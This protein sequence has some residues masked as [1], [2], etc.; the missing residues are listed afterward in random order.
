MEFEQK[1]CFSLT[2]GVLIFGTSVAVCNKYR[3]SREGHRLLK[4]LSTA[5]LQGYEQKVI[6]PN[7]IWL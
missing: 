7:P 2:T 1:P 5:N 4:I 3:M 6:P